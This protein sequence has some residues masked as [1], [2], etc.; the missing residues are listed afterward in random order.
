MNGKQRSLG[1]AIDTMIAALTDLTEAQQRTALLAVLS[2]LGVVPADFLRW[3]QGAPPSRTIDDPADRAVLAPLV[4]SD[5]RA[6]REEK[7]VRSAKDMACLVAYYLTD[8]APE[9]ERKSTVTAAD[10]EKYFKQAGYKL[11][12][13]LQQLLIDTK[14]AGLFDSVAR[15]EYRLNTV[16]YNRIVHDLPEHLGKD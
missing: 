12:A 9:P 1:Y 4:R 2:D 16:G 10:M 8:V 15:G 13:R 3:L 5:I 6:L 7:K 14:Q 11:P